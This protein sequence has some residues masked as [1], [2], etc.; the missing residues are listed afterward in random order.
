MS[1]CYDMVYRDSKE[2]AKTIRMSKSGRF[3]KVEKKYTNFII[4]YT[5]AIKN[6]KEK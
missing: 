2:V 4:F 1:R 3:T 6:Y 5:L